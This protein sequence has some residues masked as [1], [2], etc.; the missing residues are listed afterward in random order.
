MQALTDI[1]MDQ[2][3]RLDDPELSTKKHLHIKG[4]TPLS[5][6]NALSA[7]WK[8]NG[9]RIAQSCEESARNGK[10]EFTYTVGIQPTILG[11]ATDTSK[12][13]ARAFAA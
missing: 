1:K 11:I 6:L 2:D 3:A 7:K 8:T 4:Q 10:A 5:I 12:Q 13:K 9:H